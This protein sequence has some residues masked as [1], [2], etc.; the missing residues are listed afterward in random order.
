MRRRPAILPTVITLLRDDGE[1][2][3][4]MEKS[5]STKCLESIYLACQRLGR[6]L[7]E[8]KSPSESLKPKSMKLFK[9]SR[10]WYKDQDTS[11]TGTYGHR[12]RK[13]GHPVRSAILKPQIGKSVVEWVT[14]SESLLLYVFCF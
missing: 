14:I 10:S 6:N 13:I 2:W 1:R 5:L 4:M 7:E 11:Q 3:R 12:L 8:Y 9:T